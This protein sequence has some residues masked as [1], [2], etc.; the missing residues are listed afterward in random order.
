MHIHTN[1]S[2]GTHTIEAMTQ[3]AIEMG[4]EYLFII[5][6]FTLFIITILYNLMFD[7]IIIMIMNYFELLLDI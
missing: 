4:L 7:F 2:D 1:W 6:Y 5:H 3:K